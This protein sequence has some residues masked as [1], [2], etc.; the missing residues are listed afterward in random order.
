MTKEL[1]FDDTL[2]KKIVYLF[3]KRVK[4]TKELYFDDTITTKLTQYGSYGSVE[5]FDPLTQNN[6]YCRPLP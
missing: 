5:P 1:H 4:M 3:N 2:V 6:R